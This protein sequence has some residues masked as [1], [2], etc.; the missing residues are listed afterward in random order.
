MEETYSFFGSTPKYLEDLFRKEVIDSGG[1]DI[2]ETPGG[3]YFRGT[4]ETGYRLCLWSRTGGRIYFILDSFQIETKEDLYRESKKIPWDTHFGIETS[5]A[6]SCIVNQNRNYSS[7]YASLLVKDGVVDSFREKYKKRPSVDTKTPH[8]R[9]F[10]YIKQTKAEL[11][12]DLSGESLHMRGYRKKSGAATLKE[13]IAAAMLFR[14]GW[15]GIAEKG[16]SL[17][18]PMCGTGTLLIEGALIAGDTAPGLLRDS[19]GFY[20]WKKHRKNI[21]ESLIK[22]ARERKANGRKN[23]PLITGYD[24]NPEAVRSAIV[25]IEAA[26]LSDYIRVKHENV[27]H[28]YPPRGSRGLLVINPPYGERLG[29]IEEL[30]GFYRSLGAKLLKDF[31]NWKASVLTA[32]VD[33]SKQIG[34]KVGRTNTLYNGN[35]K[36]VLAHFNLEQ[37]NLFSEPGGKKKYLSSGG[38]MFENRIKK[39]LK[40]LRKWAKN[41]KIS[42]YRIYDRDLPEYAAAIDFYEDKWVN[43]QEYK[44][45][46]EIDREKTKRRLNDIIEISGRTL[47][48]EKKNIFLKQR[49]KQRGKRQ[50]EKL[51]AKSD[52]FMIKENG[53]SFL[54]NFT[55]YLDTGI[56]LDHRGIRKMIKDLSCSKRVLNLFCYT[57]TATV[58]AAS[59]KAL[60]TTSVDSS[61]TYLDW[62][63]RNMKINGFSEKNHSFIHKDCL[64]WIL[65]SREKFDL[66]FLDPPTFSNSGSRDSPFDLQKD[67]AGLLESTLKLLS[68]NGVL[69]FSC[70]YRKFRPDFS[71]FKNYSIEDITSST[72]PED[73]KRNKRIHYCWIIRHINHATGDIF[74]KS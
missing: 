47:N 14:A 16:E 59:G 36:C 50:Y 48:I 43:I 35:I 67:Y 65:E 72:I 21:W 8:F 4:M 57:G 62:A 26:D 60:S 5:F 29:E 41:N 32:N 15:P 34:I 58:Y 46:P 70:N 54:V 73:F 63:K 9:I 55:G 28:T 68:R 6:V 61:N 2:K 38:E 66:I 27:L 39:N 22:E 23:I 40:K 42:S 10:L 69:V 51:S 33:L 74:Q 19:F 17:I 31:E 24:E 7:Q 56:F 20:H 53:L 44:A 25:N 52:F 49:K 64:T 37:K 45:P 71:I 12:I 3:V 18:D 13:N 1:S 30:K 11:S